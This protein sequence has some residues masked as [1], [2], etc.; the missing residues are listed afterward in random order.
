MGTY[1]DA[2]DKAGKRLREESA[3]KFKAVIIRGKPYELLIDDWRIIKIL[4]FKG[5]GEKRTFLD[6]VKELKEINY[7]NLEKHWDDGN[8]EYI[9]RLDEYIM[10]NNFQVVFG[11]DD[12]IVKNRR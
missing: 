3:F 8:F 2:M 6:L 1:S 4:E 10:Q 12:I 7:K 11:K 9:P 5:T